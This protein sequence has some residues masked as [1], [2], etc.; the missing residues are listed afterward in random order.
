MKTREQLIKEIEIVRVG[1]ATK[2]FPFCSSK[3]L[4]LIVE[5]CEEVVA[6]TYSKDYAVDKILKN[7]KKLK[8]R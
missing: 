5:A 8:S 6:S 3:I 2:P 1:F 4:D 7:L